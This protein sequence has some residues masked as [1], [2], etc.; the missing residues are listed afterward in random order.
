MPSTSI[1]CGIILILIGIVGYVNGIS[2]GHASM[3]ALIPAFFGIALTLLGFIAKAKDGL[4]KHLMHVA[5]LVALIGFIA[6]AVRAV[7]K[8]GEI[9]SSPAVLAQTAMAVVCL[10]FVLLSIRSFIAARRG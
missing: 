6:T 5:V 4:R 1:I 9:A 3:T 8:L 7:P 2:S 10:A